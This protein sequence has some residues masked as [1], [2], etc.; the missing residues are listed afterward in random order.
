[1]LAG[2]KGPYAS[3]KAGQKHTWS[4]FEN[5]ASQARSQGITGQSGC[6]IRWAN[7]CLNTSSNPMFPTSTTRP[8]LSPCMA[9]SLA[10]AQH[11][12][13]V[14]FSNTVHRCVKHAV[15]MDTQSSSVSM[16]RSLLHL[17]V[18]F[19]I[20]RSRKHRACQHFP[21]VNCSLN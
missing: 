2:C 11:M 9:I 21:S 10:E 4:S 20:M 5:R 13:F 17:L 18:G 7:L 15:V 12:P 19:L 14:G 1:M 16:D 8:V 3:L 6:K